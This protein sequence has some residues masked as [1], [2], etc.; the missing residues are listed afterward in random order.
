MVDEKSVFR[1][2]RP[3]VSKIQGLKSTRTCQGTC[4]SQNHSPQPLFYY[5]GRGAPQV[6]GKSLL[7]GAKDTYIEATVRTL[8]ARPARRD[9]GRCSILLPYLNL[10]FSSKD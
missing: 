6:I 2:V 9:G 3:R 1:G 10:R 7:S 4:H 8:L 5:S